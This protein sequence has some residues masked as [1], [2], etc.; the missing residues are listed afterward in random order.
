MDGVIR[1]AAKKEFTDLGL[2]VKINK[3][4]KPFYFK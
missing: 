1:L 3:R 2:T 4:E